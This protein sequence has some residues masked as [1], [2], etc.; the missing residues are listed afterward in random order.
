MNV[1]SICLAWN[2]CPIWGKCDLKFEKKDWEKCPDQPMKEVLEVRTGNIDDGLCKYCAKKADCRWLEYNKHKGYC[3]P[4]CRMYQ[5]QLGFGAS[6]GLPKPAEVYTLPTQATQTVLWQYS[7]IRNLPTFTIKRND[8]ELDLPFIIQILTLL[9]IVWAVY[10]GVSKPQQKGELTD[11]VF[12]E[13]F[14]QFDRELANLR[15]NHIHTLDSKLSQHITDNANSNI[16]TVRML[17]RI[18][19]QIE[20]LLKK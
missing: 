12:A 4:R 6:D 9:G 20:T 15:D 16:E 7:T 19:T 13:R 1:L 3:V 5:E 10:N 17:S 8:M 18:E 14:T 2:T 11:A